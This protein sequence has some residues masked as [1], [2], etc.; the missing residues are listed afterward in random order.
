MEIHIK[1]NKKMKLQLGTD[2]HLSKILGLLLASK[3]SF[4]LEK[5]Y[6]HT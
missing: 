1:S 4:N 2:E 5:C 3:A 6:I